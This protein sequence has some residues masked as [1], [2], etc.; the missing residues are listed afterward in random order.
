MQVLAGAWI[1][2]R[3]ADRTRGES[4]VLQPDVPAATVSPESGKRDL[5]LQLPENVVTVCDDAY[6]DRLRCDHP[7]AVD[8]RALG[9]ALVLKADSLDRGRVV[10][11]ASEQLARGLAAGGLHLEARI[12]GFYRGEEDCVVMGASLH[13]SRAGLG[14]PGRVGHVNGLLGRPAASGD[15]SLQVTVRA[16]VEDAADIAELIGETFAAYPTPSH[17]PAYV[18]EQISEGVPFRVV[19][20]D[21]EL[22]A[23]ASADLVRDARTAELTDCATRPAA[24][25]RG[26]MQAIL[27]DLMDDL[28]DLDYPTAFT[29]ARAAI[30]GVNLA[31][32]RLGFELRGTMNQSCRIGTGL[33]DMNVW[34]RTL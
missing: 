17:E 10:V 5:T 16:A 8:G 6:S 21:G 27:T 30:P 13:A 14:Q 12:P 7:G 24:R 4:F 1:R 33:E 31:F 34:S 3:P 11:L 22:I 32:E 25:G 15:R 2:V 29:L 19:R 9:E 18:A 26:L 28:R 20:D 23:C